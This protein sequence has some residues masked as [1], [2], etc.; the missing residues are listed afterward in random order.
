MTMTLL[1]AAAKITYFSRSPWASY[2]APP[3]VIFRTYRSLC[4]LLGHFDFYAAYSVF[5]LSVTLSTGSSTHDA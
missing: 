2:I 4:L 1:V 5:G 3:M